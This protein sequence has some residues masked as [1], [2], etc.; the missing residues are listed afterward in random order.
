MK[1]PAVVSALAA[2]ALF[3]VSTPLAKLL[4][5]TVDPWLL[6]ALFYLGS[7]IGL[8]ALRLLTRGADAGL[9]R[10]DLPW[11]AGAVVSGGVIG[12]VLL[13]VG[14]ASTDASTASLLLTLEGGATALI[15]WFV[16]QE[17]FDRRIAVGLA[18]IIIGAAI[19]AWEPAA[20][21]RGAFG[22]LAIAGACLA[23][24]I[25]NNLTRQVALASPVQIAMIKGLVA[26]AV[27]LLLATASGVAMPTPSIALLAGAIGFVGYGLSIVLFIGALRHLGAARTGA[28]F[29]TAPFL[30]AVAAVV[31]LGEPLSLRLIASAALMATGVWLHL[32]E[33]HE[34]EHEHGAVEHDHRH[35]HDEHHRHAH[36]AG[37]PAAEPHSHRHAHVRLRHSHPHLP[38][39]HHQHSH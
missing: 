13:M 28:Y 26:G 18:C 38:D 22:P 23:W 15:A 29:S 14:L 36:A 16:F 8:A 27:N 21:W 3:G 32:T 24:G 35:V 33:R 25:D 2:A 31:V 19:L 30:G 1:I 5:G 17:N 4:I 11:I 9:V 39:S 20:S 37:D 12:P 6:A 10:R 34:H 7:G